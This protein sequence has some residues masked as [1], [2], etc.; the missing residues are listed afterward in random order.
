MQWSLFEI[1]NDDLHTPLPT[2]GCTILNE[3]NLA[4]IF[5]GYNEEH[6]FLNSLYIFDIQKGIFIDSPNSNSNSSKNLLN[7][8]IQKKQNLPEPRERHSAII[9]KDKHFYFGGIGLIDGQKKS[10]NDL[11]TYTPDKTKPIWNKA[12]LYNE[13]IVPKA[14]YSHTMVMKSSGEAIILFGGVSED[15]CFNDVWF[16]TFKVSL[17]GES[18]KW[19]KIEP[20]SELI[21]SERF[22]HSTTICNSKMF[23]YGGRNKKIIFNDLW[24]YDYN[25][26]I[27]KEIKL[28]KN[29][30]PRY[31]HSIFTVSDLIFLFGGFTSKFQFDTELY[32]ID[33][34]QKK[35]SLL[36]EK[37]DKEKN[38]ILK[39]GRFN[40]GS[41]VI[42]DDFFLFGGIKKTS[43]G[44]ERTNEFFK[45]TTGYNFTGKKKISH[46]I[47]LDNTLGEGNQAK[48]LKVLDSR[49]KKEY[50]LKRI[51]ISSNSQGIQIIDPINKELDIL[52]IINHK[53]VLAI[54]ESFMFQESENWYFALVSEYCEVGDLYEYIKQ[55]PDLKELDLLKL[56]GQIIE[57]LDYIHSKKIIHRDIKPQNIL[58]AKP[59]EGKKKKDD[60]IVKIADFGLST[61]KLWTNSLVGTPIYMAPE[62]YSNQPYTIS[63]DIYSFGKLMYFILTKDELNDEKSRTNSNSNSNTN[64]ISMKRTSNSLFGQSPSSSPSSFS[65]HYASFSINLKN[66]S[67]KKKNFNIEY[68]ISPFFFKLSEKYKNIITECI[69]LNPELR[70]KSDEVLKKIKEIIDILKDENEDSTT[71]ETD[72]TTEELKKELPKTV[73]EFLLEIGFEKYTNL[74]ISY[75][76]DIIESLYYL[77]KQDLKN[78]NIPYGHIRKILDEKGKYVFDNFTVNL[79]SLGS[80]FDS[81]YLKEEYLHIFEREDYDIESFFN[82]IT[83]DE[84]KEFGLKKEGHI[85]R[86]LL[87]LDTYRNNQVLTFDSS[88]STN[89]SMIDQEG[90]DE[91]SMVA[92]SPLFSPRENSSHRSSIVFK[93]SNSLVKSMNSPTPILNLKQDSNL[94]EIIDHL[95]LDENIFIEHGIKDVE[96]LKLFDKFELTQIGV[97]RGKISKIMKIIQDVEVINLI[98]SIPLDDLSLELFFQLVNLKDEFLDFFLTECFDLETFSTLE[99]FDLRKYGFVKI[100][101][102]KKI[103]KYL[104]LLKEKLKKESKKIEKNEI[105]SISD[106]LNSFG[107]LEYESIFKKN[108]KMIWALLKLD[109]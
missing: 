59:E 85:S 74:F 1:E 82:D 104:N 54:H 45:L 103:K 88:L 70:P 93:N 95:N 21:P 94:N 72:S 75:G 96:T 17:S 65:K 11:W 12:K 46:Y 3:A 69:Q 42:R 35:I 31:S 15:E 66:I 34:D 26:Y 20:K 41:I 29:L 102:L 58:L 16:L 33:L 105:Q 106:W 23:I 98:D 5:G 89:S 43:K 44:F 100:G 99:R 81:L 4:Y 91:L 52:R 2:S 36:N 57:G 62:C 51:K 10:L 32:N 53:N 97:K 71:T 48:V 87:A 101:H 73:K 90:H 86:I 47:D 40:F 64:S 24:E 14:R 27:W 67:E 28:K 92:T 78:L 107:L 13:K 19:T 9:F 8:L 50:A 109:I 6:R 108:L 84:L 80:F 60:L 38:E 61:T 77:S 18:M 30:I 63:A 22:D 68:G 56:I 76:F 49:N 7:L 25:N 55:S 37:N 79:N 83:K 39:E